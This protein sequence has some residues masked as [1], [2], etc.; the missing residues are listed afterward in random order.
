MKKE[1]K[2]KEVIT[3]EQGNGSFSGNGSRDRRL[4]FQKAC[5]ASVPV[6]LS[7]RAT[8]LLS[9]GT[10]AA[11]PTRTSRRYGA[12]FKGSVFSLCGESQGG[13]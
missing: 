1:K 5:V 4:P 12:G 10:K 7:L 2:K 8:C 11:P 9:R 6:V 13:H 3:K